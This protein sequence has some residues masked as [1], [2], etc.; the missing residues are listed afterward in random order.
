MLSVVLGP[1]QAQLRLR[2]QLVQLAPGLLLFQP[3]QALHAFSA[4][5]VCGQAALQPPLLSPVLNA[6]PEPSLLTLKQRQCKLVSTVLLEDGPVLVLERVHLV[7]LEPTH[8]RPVPHRFQL[9]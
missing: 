9:V 2:A 6:L 1:G 7:L 8:Q 3:R 4:L 5:L